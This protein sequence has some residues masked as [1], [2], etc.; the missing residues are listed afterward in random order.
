MKNRSRINRGESS[1]ELL[2]LGI[3]ALLLACGDGGDAPK[4]ADQRAFEAAKKEAA[5]TDEATAQQNAER[6]NEAW[7][8][9]D[10]AWPEEPSAVVAIEIKDLGEIRIGLYESIAPQTVAHFIQITQRGLYDESI[11]HRVIK[12]FMIQGGDPGTKPRPPGELIPNY[13]NVRVA[14]EF[15][16]TPHERGVVSM[17]NR[18]TENSA[19][20]QFFILQRDS[21][22]LDGQYT[23]FGRVIEGMD[24]VD[25]IA[26]A[27]VDTYG[28]WGS[29]DRPMADVVLLKATVEGEKVVKE[30]GEV[31]G[32]GEV[33]AEG[34]VASA[35]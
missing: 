3:L 28:R 6:A 10:F 11:F 17:A 12:D 33:V 18:G 31:N 15:N 5:G 4:S 8:N 29:A 20:T 19:D 16:A 13:P 23:A 21:P 1:W 2:A 9:Q 14:D 35:G 24:V 30:R 22:H 7:K 32:E 25:A 27:E 34:E 26:N